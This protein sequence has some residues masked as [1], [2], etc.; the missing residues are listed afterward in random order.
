MTR[1]R[2]KGDPITLDATRIALSGFSS[3]G[4]LAL[5]LVTSVSPPQL[6]QPWPCVVPTKYPSPIPVL[7]YYPSFDTRQ[8]PSERPRPQGLAVSTGF[9]AGL[10]LEDELMPKY[11]SKEDAKSPRASPGLAD[12][13][14]IHEQARMQLIL[15]E[16][17]SLNEQSETWVK[18]VIEDGRG[19]HLLVDRVVGVKHGW[20]QFPDGWLS[21]QD[22]QKKWDIFTKTSQFIRDTWENVGD[23]D[24]GERINDGEEEHFVRE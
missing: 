7:L 9:F 22:K 18:K 6:P 23:R 20:T 5:N 19:G 4:N 11:I 24:R 15:P 16:L 3:G 2:I 12:V 21:D 13:S 10:R 1:R 8:L 14:G 17:D